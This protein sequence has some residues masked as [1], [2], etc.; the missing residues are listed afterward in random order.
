MEFW[1]WLIIKALMVMVNQV[2]VTLQPAEKSFTEDDLKAISARILAA[3][4][5]LGAALRA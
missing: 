2:E 3:A 1:F 4:A 5:A